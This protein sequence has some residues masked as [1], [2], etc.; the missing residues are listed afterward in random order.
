VKIRIN[1]LTPEQI[2]EKVAFCREVL[3]ATVDL[4]VD[5]VQGVARKPWTLQESLAV[6]RSLEPY[7][8]LWVEEP[9]EVTDYAG[10]A[11][12]RRQ[13][14]LPIA[15]GET[16][17]SLT[18]AE[19]YLKA[20]ALDLF[21]PDAAMLGGLG[22]FR[23]VAQRC[24]REGVNIA[25]HTWAGGV[26][27]MGNYHAA[28]A[29]KNCVIL[30]LPNNPYPLREEFLVEP[31]DVSDGTVHAPTA[32]GLGVKLPDDAERR[33]PY[34]PGSFYR[35]L[36]HP[37]RRATLIDFIESLVPRLLMI[38][39]TAERLR[40]NW[41]TLLL[42]VQSDDRIDFGLLAEELEQFVTGARERRVLQWQCGRVLH[43]VGSGV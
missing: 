31:L 33:Y 14:E 29:S 36:G 38:P 40:G 41:A 5:A 2:V 21:Q 8:V 26:G 20:G 34:R 18:E 7:R 25:V 16:V 39:L 32:P 23:E 28:F 9:C 19:A 13:T 6:V 43:P 42:P 27:I 35:V 22:L 37:G 3:G 4:A 11:E 30:E 15:G 24:E 10:F 17:T 12:V 1:F